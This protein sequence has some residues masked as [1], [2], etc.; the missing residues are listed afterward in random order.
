DDEVVVFEPFYDSYAAVVALGQA[1]LIT[2]PLRGDGYQPDH[3]EL[4][5]AVTDRTRI[6]LLNNP[7][8]PT[9]VQFDHETLS[10]IVELAHE[11][12]AIIVSDEVYEH[13]IFDGAHTP[14]AALSGARMRTVTISSGG[15]TF[16]TTG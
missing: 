6:I 10:L 15:K 13:L 16:N 2:V 7:H 5:A 12:D 4:R 3:D 11:H 14:I 1:R 8:N 9:G